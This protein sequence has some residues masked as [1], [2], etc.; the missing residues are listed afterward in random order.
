MPKYDFNKDLPIDLLN[1][2]VVFRISSQEM[3]YDKGLFFMKV[4]EI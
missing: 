2:L 4:F 3:I 1:L